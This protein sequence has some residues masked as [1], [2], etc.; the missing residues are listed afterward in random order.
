MKCVLNQTS[1][2]PTGV[3][4]WFLATVQVRQ[5]YVTTE[6]NFV[7]DKTMQKGFSLS[8]SRDKARSSKFPVNQVC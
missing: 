3:M 7:T 4:R 5:S 6:F 1:T 8:G 2:W